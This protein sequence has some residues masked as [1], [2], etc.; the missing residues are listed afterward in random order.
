MQKWSSDDL[1]LERQMFTLLRQQI[2][3]HWQ[4]FCHLGE[5][6]TSALILDGI[7]ATDI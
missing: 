6:L 3:V 2:E 7:I 5:R 1:Q 4:R